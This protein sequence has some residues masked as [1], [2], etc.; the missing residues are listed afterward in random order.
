M[1]ETRSKRSQ[2][3][4]RR[5]PRPDAATT[6]RLALACT[7]AVSVVYEPLRWLC[8]DLRPS[9]DDDLGGVGGVGGLANMLNP[10][11][12]CTTTAGGADAPYCFR[13]GLLLGFTPFALV[14]LAALVLPLALGAVVEVATAARKTGGAGTADSYGG[15][16][17]VVA[18]ADQGGMVLA[19]DQL[20]DHL[21]LLAVQKKRWPFRNLAMA[22]WGAMNFIWS[23][24]GPPTV[25][26][27]DRA[28]SIGAL[29]TT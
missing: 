8:T 29:Q 28:P 11:A 15:R 22:T 20:A 17:A 12:N 27:P 19:A 1:T 23:A 2:L 7:L 13:P 3:D 21:L 16:A 10:H 4:A 9:L 14:V 18:A 26:H 5:T 25:H 24:A 6:M